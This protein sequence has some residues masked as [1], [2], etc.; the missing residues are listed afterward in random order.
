MALCKN[1]EKMDHRWFTESL[2]RSPW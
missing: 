1:V 2:R